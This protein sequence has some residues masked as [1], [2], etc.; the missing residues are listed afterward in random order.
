MGEVI[1]DCTVTNKKL[2]GMEVVTVPY[3]TALARKDDGV[4]ER[5]TQR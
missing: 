4:V 5:N 2:E 3:I 1:I